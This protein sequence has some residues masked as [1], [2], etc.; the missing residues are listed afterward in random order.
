MQM[1]KYTQKRT[2]TKKCPEIFREHASALQIINNHCGGL[3]HC[4]SIVD[5]LA[6]VLIGGIIRESLKL[7]LHGR[8]KSR[9]LNNRVLRVFVS[10]VRVE[11]SHVEYGFLKVRF[12]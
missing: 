6:E 3:T 8:R 11:I 2:G 7:L 9:V 4:V 10:E 5:A 12:A 1:Y